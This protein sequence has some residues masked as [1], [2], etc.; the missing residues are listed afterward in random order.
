ML[1][2]CDYYTHK[3]VNGNHLSANPQPAWLVLPVFSSSDQGQTDSPQ[4]I[5]DSLTSHNEVHSNDYLGSLGK[6]GQSFWI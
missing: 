1:L 4:L 5:F 2:H 6:S 3:S